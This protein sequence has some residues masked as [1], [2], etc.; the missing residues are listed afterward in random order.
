MLTGITKTIIWSNN[1]F[2]V[3]HLVSLQKS[4]LFAKV[5]VFLSQDLDLSLQTHD[6]LL[7]W[8]LK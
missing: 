4:H 5:M 2:C 1:S 3:E 8:V 7:T 6:Q